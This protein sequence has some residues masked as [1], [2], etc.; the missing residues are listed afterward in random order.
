M[1]KI[2]FILFLMAGLLEAGAQNVYDFKAQDI[3]GQNVELS[4]YKGKALLI[5]NVAS[6]CGFTYQYEG[7]QNLYLKYKDKGLVILG[8]PCNQFLSQEPG[9]DEEIA[10]FCRLKYDVTF[11]MFSKIEVNGNNSHPL[12]TYLR[13]ELPGNADDGKIGWNFTKFLID[14]NGKPIGR[15]ASKVKPE[16]LEE[17]I[18]QALST[19][20]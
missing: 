15:F 3:N 8:F 12:Y 16:E 14:R 2:L 10:Q 19:I 4:A 5:V 1:K 17:S 11:P 13:K 7:L 6:K 20:E 18:I 9:S